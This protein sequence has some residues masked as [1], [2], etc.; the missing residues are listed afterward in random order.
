MRASDHLTRF[1]VCGKADLPTPH[2]SILGKRRVGRPPASVASSRTLCSAGSAAF[3]IFL[4]DGQIAAIRDMDSVPRSSHS[5]CPRS[6]PGSQESMRRA[7]HATHCETSAHCCLA[8]QYPFSEARPVWLN[9]ASASVAKACYRNAPSTK[10]SWR[11]PYHPAKAA[12]WSRFALESAVVGCSIDGG[13]CVTES[14]LEV[15]ATI[16]AWAAFRGR[17]QLCLE[18][19][20]E[21]QYFSMSAHHPALEGSRLFRPY[22]QIALF[23]DGWHVEIS[24]NDRLDSSLQLDDAAAGQLSDA[25]WRQVPDVGN[26][27]FVAMTPEEAGERANSALRRTLTIAHPTLLR[28]E[29]AGF[30]PPAS[31]PPDLSPMI[32]SGS[33]GNGSVRDDP[34]PQ[35]I[36][37]LIIEDREQLIAATSSLL[38]GWLGQPIEPDQDGVFAFKYDD[39]LLLVEPSQ[40][41]EPWLHVS[42][43]VVEEVSTSEGLLQYLNSVTA[44]LHAVQVYAA[45]DC[46][47]A[48]LD[49][50][51]S[52][53]LSPS[54]T[55]GIEALIQ[56]AQQ[57]RPVLVEQ[58]LGQPMYEPQLG[59]YL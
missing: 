5:T 36:E 49:L 56:A 26:W 6:R 44:G 18:H 2:P 19:M 11:T 9:A 58:F 53:F 10:C 55:F 30:F 33:L 37:A 27:L 42:A 59:G 31:S 47:F 28:T 52:P 23:A 25:G 46:V 51:G 32:T 48:R 7:A 20:S 16:H 35:T 24:G 8:R 41:A 50:L 12:T 17:L 54:L 3:Y 13:A 39:V 1:D 45:E 43:L 14:A 57:L 38:S 4:A 34:L 15:P 29:N 21:G 22:C 40:T